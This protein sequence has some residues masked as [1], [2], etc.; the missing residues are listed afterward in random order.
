MKAQV[1]DKLYLPFISVF[2]FDVVFEE[3]L[4]GDEN[5]DCGY[6][7]FVQ[8]MADVLSG[9]PAKVGNRMFSSLFSVSHSA[10][11]D[12]KVRKAHIGETR[13]LGK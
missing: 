9:M 10:S 6:G 7:R 12:L 13:D 8:D 3:D 5:D 2:K 1:R 11:S 4:K